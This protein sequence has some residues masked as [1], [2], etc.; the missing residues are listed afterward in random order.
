M[1]PENRR[2]WKHDEL[3]NPF[4]RQKLLVTKPRRRFRLQAIH[5]YAGVGL[6]VAV[7]AI[8]VITGLAAARQNEQ[9]IKTQQIIA[10]FETRDAFE[11]LRGQTRLMIYWQDAFDKI[12]RKWDQTW[13]TYQFGPYQDTMGNHLVAIVGPNNELRFLHGTHDE[14]TFTSG[15]FIRAEGLHALLR[16]TRRAG[17]QQPPP[18]PEGIIVVHGKPYF[19]VAA[20]VTPEE[21]NDLALGQRTPFMALFMKPVSVAQYEG[22]ATGFDADNVEITTSRS[23]LPGQTSYPLN[24]AE[25]HP[26]AYVHWKPQLPGD[27][28]LHSVTIPLAALLLLL[29][30]IQILVVHR[31]LRLQRQLLAVEA[32]SVAAHEQSRL[33]SVF[34]GTISHELRTPLNAIIGH[35]DV[36]CCHLFGPLG[37][38]RNAEYI[39]DIRDS[40]RKL[41]VTVNDLIEIARIEAGDTGKVVDAFNPVSAAR[42]AVSSTRAAARIRN[43]H[44]GLRATKTSCWCRG[45][46]VSLSQALE[47]ILDNAIRYSNPG[48]T[49]TVAVD[50]T[51]ENVLIEVRD[52]GEGIASERLADLTRPFAHPGNHMVAQGNKGLGFGIPIARGLV[53]LMGGTLEIESKP[54]VGTTVRICLPLH[55]PKQEQ[56]AGEG[57]PLD[58]VSTGGVIWTGRG[59]DFVARR[60]GE[61]G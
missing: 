46:L 41:L 13:V 58:A 61:G 36:L 38:P 20:L 57:E 4:G 23:P 51:P 43:V 21:K 3:A 45:S 50:A 28:F 12:V 5:V 35:A 48:G 22:F 10:R 47:R 19:A 59:R 26:V 27:V 60:I 14:P 37:S 39:R 44:I 2:R 9:S 55:V 54:D 16:V 15:N 42:H 33:K 1:W 49:V 7:L 25:G 30:L 17:L 18:I 24:D 32:D 8:A 11:Y 40:G 34:L 6:V 52:R 31:W 53:E 56:A 29:M